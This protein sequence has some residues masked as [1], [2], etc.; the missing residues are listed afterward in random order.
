MLSIVNLRVYFVTPI[1]LKF[2]TSTFENYDKLGILL[3]RLI[4]TASQLNCS[5]NMGF[6]P[7][8]K[9]VATLG[10]YLYIY[11]RSYPFL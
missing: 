8:S 6:I 2:F 3:G 10:S 9:E 4:Y 1:V 7:D 11:L 5:Q